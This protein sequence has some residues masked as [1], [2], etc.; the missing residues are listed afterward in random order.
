MTSFYLI[1]KYHNVLWNV[2]TYRH[3]YVHTDTDTQ[4]HTRIIIIIY[5]YLY[6]CIY[7]YLFSKKKKKELSKL[8]IWNGFLC[9][10][11]KIHPTSGHSNRVS[12]DPHITHTFPTLSLG[13]SSPEQLRTASPMYLSAQLMTHTVRIAGISA[14][15]SLQ[16]KRKESVV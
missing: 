6:M 3:V 4:R 10:S 13:M 8:I 14:T 2:G 15:A 7:V 1:L 11:S 12:Q 5:N 9:Q 16:Q